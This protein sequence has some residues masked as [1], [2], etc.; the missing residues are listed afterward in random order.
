M[1]SDEEDVLSILLLILIKK[2]RRGRQIENKSKKRSFWVRDMYRDREK[3]GATRL[4]N[5][6]K[7]SNR[8]DYFK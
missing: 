6:M 7:L 5:K 4:L 1:D 8:E 3:Y 2:R